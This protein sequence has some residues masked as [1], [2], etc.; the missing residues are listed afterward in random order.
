MAIQKLKTKTFRNLKNVHLIPGER[1]NVLLGANGSG[2]T[3]VLEAIY[4]LGYG[5]SFRCSNLQAAIGYEEPS[6]LSCVQ[7]KEPNRQP[8]YLGMSKEKDKRAQVKLSGQKIRSLSE[9][10]SQMPALFISPDS[11]AL[12]V[13]GPEKRRR[14]VDW[15]TFH[16]EPGFSVAW[17]NFSKVLKQRNAALKAGSVRDL[18]AWDN[19]WIKC[20][21]TISKMRKSYLAKLMPCFN[22][23]LKSLAPLEGL[24]ID[25]WQGWSELEPLKEAL[26]RQRSSEL[27]V[28]HSLVGPQRA[29]LQI[30]LYD[31]PAA[32]LLSRGQQKMLVCALFLAQGKVLTETLQ[33]ECIYLVDDLSS[34]L[35]E[36]HRA[37]FLAHINDMGV[38]CFIT[39]I[40][41]SL[42]L[43]L[44]KDYPHKAYDVKG[45]E[46]K[47]LIV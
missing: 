10:S 18:M 4:V 9:L 22:R 41:Q 26:E 31:Y 35:D 40:E 24:R 38:Q 29:D 32:Q 12:L 13:D 33:K 6:F 42:L 46:I 17:Q 36:N 5:R 7:L 14:F 25:F 16:S 2:K 27:R 30:S 45:G 43:P 8:F 34:E 1:F 28:G 11:F 21:E 39:G 15:G 19:E 3:S 23:V 37:K 20:A 44:V 47:E